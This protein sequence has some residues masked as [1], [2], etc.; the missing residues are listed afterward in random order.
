ML[1]VNEFILLIT[2][3]SGTLSLLI[4]RSPQMIEIVSPG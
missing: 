1:W 2:G 4:F 3:L